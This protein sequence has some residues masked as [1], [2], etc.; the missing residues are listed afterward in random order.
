MADFH[1][2]IL[3]IGGGVVGCSVLYH[4]TKKGVTD[5][6]LLERMQLTSGSSWHAAGSMHTLNGDPNVAA[7]QKYTINLY[8]EL[9]EISG[10]SIGHHQSGGFY[11]ASSEQRMTL[12][13]R[14]A[15][16]ARFLG[17]DAQI[18]DVQEVKKVIP[19]MEE[20]YFVG[21]L[22]D[23]DNGHIDPA[24]VTHAY[25]KAAKI[26]GAKI[27]IESPVTS[28]ERRGK[29][30]DVTT[31]KGVWHARIVIN[32]GG[33]W[34]R[35]VG[36]MLG[37]FLPALPME[38]QYLLTDDIPEIVD[39]PHEVPNIIDTDGENYFRQ[40]GNGMLIGTYE[41]RPVAWSPDETP[42]DFGHELLNDD[43]DRMSDNLTTAFER[44]PVLAKAGVKKVVN[45]PMTFAP[46]GNPLV[47]PV[48]GVPGFYAACGVMAGFSQGGGIG[49][50]LSEWIIDG[51]PSIDVYGMDVG[52]FGPHA[53]KGYLSS[54]AHENYRRRFRV[55][56]PNE[57]LPDGRP[58][59]TTPVYDLMA[60]HHAVFGVSY[61]MES[62]IWF[63]DSAEN[64]HE[65]WGFGRT[66]AFDYIVR[67]AKAVREN[68]GLIEISGYSKYLVSGADAHAFLDEVFASNLPAQGKVKLAPM[69]NHV[70][71]L[72]GDLSIAN[73][74]GGKYLI[75]GSGA[76]QAIHLRWFDAHRGDK[77]V[78]IDN[79]TLSH[80]GFSI[81]GPRA[82][83]IMETLTAEAPTQFMSVGQVD[84]GKVP[85][86]VLRVSF[87]GEYGYEIFAPVEYHRHLFETLMAAGEPFG[88][89][90]FGSR[91]LLAL[92]LEKGFGAWNMEYTGD[93]S[94][95][96]SELRH[97]VNT[98]KATNFIGKAALLAQQQAGLGDTTGARLTLFALQ[99]GLDYD[100]MGY[101][102]I[103]QGDEVVGHTRSGG[104]G[105][106]CAKSL[107][108]GYV[109]TD[110][111]ATGK[112]FTTEILGE[113]VGLTVLK[114]VPYDPK[115]ERM[116]G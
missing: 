64:A 59:L 72:V 25:A 63:A 47:G 52:R 30:F 69:V 38:H 4:L 20:K 78:T 108:L 43:L 71:K 56:F 42:W 113:R 49:L 32:A 51:Q 75:I 22:Y 74:G 54:K 3:V 112:P 109:S 1:T 79:L 61:G 2:D 55:G 5:C 76:M 29:G 26:N 60:Q 102:P 10:Q 21:A 57:Q 37:V 86:I 90:L 100:S 53:R 9:E 48:P 70:G 14:E 44:F 87:T 84:L 110:S 91:A 93:Y 81:A 15:A 62:P 19:F 77:A 6:T 104:Y 103:Y 45:G 27:E 11:L 12:L 7:L 83:Q 23:P 95:L 35:E 28:I 73:L 92:R 101:E 16:K 88:M 89:Q 67:E 68:A 107:A 58:L 99:D 65:N 98:N 24:S 106:G 40:E 34:G 33:L 111:L 50:A 13:R 39:L 8:K 66:N 85:S 105:V 18:V 17:I 36:K 96:Q 116:R 97:F 46:D 31:P 80:P 41:Q 94:P 114:D 82:K 115:G